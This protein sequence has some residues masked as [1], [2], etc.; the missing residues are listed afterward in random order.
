MPARHV[1][2]S[3]APVVSALNLPTAHAVHTADVNAIVTLPYVPAKQ[4]VHADVPE[5]STL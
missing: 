2:H 1:V 5:V 4:T 3:D